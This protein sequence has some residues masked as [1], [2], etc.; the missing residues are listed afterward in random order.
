MVIV[1][2]VASAIAGS[3]SKMIKEML[4]AALDSFRKEKK[5]L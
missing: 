4:D 1:A 5:E 2:V 3:K